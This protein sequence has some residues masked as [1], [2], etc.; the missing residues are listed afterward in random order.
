M[1]SCCLPQDRP[2]ATVTRA[3]DSA[4]SDHVDASCG[5]SICAA[6]L[7]FFSSPFSFSHLSSFYRN[8]RGVLKNYATSLVNEINDRENGC[9]PRWEKVPPLYSVYSYLL[10]VV[11]SFLPRFVFSSLSFIPFL[12]ATGPQ[13]LSAFTD[14]VLECSGLLLGSKIQGMPPPSYSLYPL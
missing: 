12:Q 4:A 7:I 11:F 14:F 1:H 9:V 3:Y 8:H 2:L 10:V 13:A 6:Y 5:E